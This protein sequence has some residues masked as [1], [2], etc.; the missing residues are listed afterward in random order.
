MSADADEVVVGVIGRAHGIR[1]DV[2]I[3]LRTDEPGRRFGVGRVLRAEDSARTFT[4]ESLHDHSGR[5]LA[6]FRELADRTAA[7][8]ARGIRLVVAVDP[9][10]LPEAEGEFY[11]RQ[12]V[13]LRVRDA[14]NEEVGTVTNVVH[15]PGQD[16]LEIETG[17]GIRL[18]P[19]VLALVPEVDLSA[20]LIRLADLPGLLA[21]LED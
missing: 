7:E 5:L 1:G 12:L 15:A 17:P 9:G 10:E 3:E 8:A 21:D 19:F 18:V 14:N 4:I 2:V 16:L 6:K 13:G 20:G 11:D